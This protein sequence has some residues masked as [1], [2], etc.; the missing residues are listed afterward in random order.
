MKKVFL[1]SIMFVFTNA[2]YAQTLGTKKQGE[3]VFGNKVVKKGEKIQPNSGVVVFGNKVVKKGDKIQPNSKP[4]FGKKESNVVNGT[5]DNGTKFNN[6]S[7]RGRE[8]SEEGKERADENRKYHK[9]HKHHGHDEHDE[10]GEHG[11]KHQDSD[12]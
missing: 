2:F 1:L 10:K 8:R 11:E 7:E 9:N 6:A 3:V 4:V 5:R 12:K